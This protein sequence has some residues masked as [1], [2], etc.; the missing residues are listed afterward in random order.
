M[1]DIRSDPQYEA[2]FSAGLYGDQNRNSEAWLDGYK[3]ATKSKEEL[4]KLGFKINGQR[5][6]DAALMV[7]GERIGLQT[8]ASLIDAEKKSRGIE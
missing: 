1:S 8:F 3:A 5:D 7:I 6:F 4:E 2:G